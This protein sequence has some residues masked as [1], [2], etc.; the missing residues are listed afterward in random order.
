MVINDAIISEDILDYLT[1]E[2]KKVIEAILDDTNKEIEC[3]SDTLTASGEGNNHSVLDNSPCSGD[4]NETLLLLVVK[5]KP[6][7]PMTVENFRDPLNFF[8][9]NCSWG[10]SSARN[11]LLEKYGDIAV[12][13]ALSRGL[14]KA[15][16]TRLCWVVQSICLTRNVDMTDKLMFTWLYH[17]K[18]LQLGGF[19]VDFAYKHLKNIAD[20]RAQFIDAE[21]HKGSP[22]YSLQ[23]EVAQLNRK[24]KEATESLEET[25]KK[26]PHEISTRYSEESGAEAKRISDALELIFKDAGEGLL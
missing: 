2:E 12:N 13:C 5:V 16:L 18:F 14:K 21:R 22:I 23:K 8:H 1:E 3:M 25:K 17:F 20:A 10:L 4:I 7:A 9:H 15:L 26:I 11:K 6:F 19:N 24:V